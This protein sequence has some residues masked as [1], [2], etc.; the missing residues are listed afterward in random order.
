M[1][2]IH[3]VALAVVLLVYSSSA[4]VAQQLFQL[5]VTGGLS[6]SLVSGYQVYQDGAIWGYHGTAKALLD[7]RPIQF[8]VGVEV[9]HIEAEV[10]DAYASGYGLY[11]VRDMD[12]AGF[13]KVP[14]ALVNAKVN[15]GNSLYFFGGGM[16]GIMLGKSDLIQDNF[17]T[18]LY[19]ANLGLVINMGEHLGLEIAEGWRHTKIDGTYMPDGYSSYQG[20]FPRIPVSYTINYFTTN[21]GLRIRFGSNEN[22]WYR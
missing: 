15:I 4:V 9:G 1:K 3:R 22:K 17:S 19:G 5:G 11:Y 6:S 20:L 16:C 13:Y 21:I 2:L 18:L 12:V 7:L 10:V 14:H 8:G